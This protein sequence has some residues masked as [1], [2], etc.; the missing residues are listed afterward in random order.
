MRKNYKG[1]FYSLNLFYFLFKFTSKMW[2]LFVCVCILYFEIHIL[3]YSTCYYNTEKNCNSWYFICDW[4]HPKHLIYINLFKCSQFFR[5]GT[6]ITLISQMLQ[7]ALLGVT[8]LSGIKAQIWT[9]T[10]AQ[11]TH[12]LIMSFFSSLG[13]SFFRSPREFKDGWHKTRLEIWSATLVWVFH[14]AFCWRLC[15]HFVCGLEM[16]SVLIEPFMFGSE[17]S[18]VSGSQTARL[19]SLGWAELG[20]PVDRRH[21]VGGNR[22]L[23]QSSG[24]KTGS[25]PDTE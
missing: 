12:P 7:E 6:R 23:E 9:Q 1:I 13:K 5:M 8:P 16:S 11:R 21:C 14:A 18:W 19:S 17:L 25:K 2:F 24:L 22:L 20:Q 10:L 15:L 4:Y 3:Q